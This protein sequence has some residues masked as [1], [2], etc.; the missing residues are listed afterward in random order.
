M[1][2]PALVV[3]CTPFSS[4]QDTMFLVFAILYLVGVTVFL[5]VIVF[6]KL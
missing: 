5:E 6:F 1:P 4:V 3:S 2:C